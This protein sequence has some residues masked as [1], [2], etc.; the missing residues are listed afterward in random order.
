[1]VMPLPNWSAAEYKA[2]VLFQLIGGIW[3]WASLV[4]LWCS[5]K[6]HISA[7]HPLVFAGILAGAGAAFLLGGFRWSAVV[8][9]VLGAGLVV[10]A[11]KVEN[12]PT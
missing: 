5:P 7:I 4:I 6:K 12:V 2:L 10:R 9:M 8:P 1:M 3:G 11:M